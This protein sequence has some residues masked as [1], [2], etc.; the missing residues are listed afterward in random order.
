M[1]EFRLVFS[2]NLGIVLC[3]IS[4]NKCN[5]ICDVVYNKIKFEGKIHS[6]V[7]TCSLKWKTDFL[8]SFLWIIET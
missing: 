3:R 1:L 2:A 4:V 7:C 8:W 5:G 6:V